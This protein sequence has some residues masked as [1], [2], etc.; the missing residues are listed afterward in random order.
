MS[1]GSSV[2]TSGLGDRACG[3]P[4]RRGS[5]AEVTVQPGVQSLPCWCFC[6]SGH[7]GQPSQ[8]SDVASACMGR[9]EALWAAEPASPM[10]IPLAHAT[11][12]P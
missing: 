12:I 5:T 7:E 2:T 9:F 11:P 1:E 6:W 3:T 4:R 10:V 8:A